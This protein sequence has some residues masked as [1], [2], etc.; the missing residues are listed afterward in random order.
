M[1]KDN[2]DFAEILERV[3]DEFHGWISRVIAGFREE[4]DKL[5]TE[6]R[7]LFAEIDPLSPDRKRFAE[8]ANKHRDY[9]AI[10]FKIKDGQDPSE[11]IWKQIKP[12]KAEYYAVDES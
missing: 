3:P 4:Y 5:L 6:A 8:L 12:D 10:L 9:A 2:Y 11:L 1:L 7:R